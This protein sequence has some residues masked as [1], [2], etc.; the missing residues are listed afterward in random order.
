MAPV[1]VCRAARRRLPPQLGGS[2]NGPRAFVARHHLG[3]ECPH[4]RWEQRLLSRRVRPAARTRRRAKLAHVVP[5]PRTDQA[6]R[7]WGHCRFTQHSASCAGRQRGG[8][9]RRVGGTSSGALAIASEHLQAAAVGE[10]H[11]SHRG[12]PPA[13]GSPGEHRRAAPGSDTEGVVGP[14]GGCQ[15]AGS[16]ARLCASEPTGYRAADSAGGP[17][18]AGR[19]RMR[20]NRRRQP[21]CGSSCTAHLLP[22]GST[23]NTNLPHGNS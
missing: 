11:R 20:P 7:N 10:P 22:S 2:E 8:S 21:R 5:R 6:Q 23:K 9:A 3:H 4:D 13:T 19:R 12:P 18:A 15:T 14:T 1:D 17:T 16:G